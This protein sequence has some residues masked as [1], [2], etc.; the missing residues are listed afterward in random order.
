MTADDAAN[1][2]YHLAYG[3]ARELMEAHGFSMQTE[4]H[5]GSAAGDAA[6]IRAE[7][8]RQLGDSEAVREGFDDAL[9]GRRPRW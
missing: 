1:V 3:L 6:Q 9:A 4:R 2:L 8:L 7:V 5:R